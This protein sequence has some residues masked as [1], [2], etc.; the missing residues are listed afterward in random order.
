MIIDTAASHSD[1]N[2]TS[3]VGLHSQERRSSHGHTIIHSIIS[4][5]FSIRP[6]GDGVATTGNFLFVS[7]LFAILM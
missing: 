5:I 3:A 1:I 6:R 4:V 7:V 2:N